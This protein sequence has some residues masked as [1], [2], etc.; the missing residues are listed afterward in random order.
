MA[1]RAQ[2]D[3]A[4]LV[5]LGGC[6]DPLPSR[7]WPGRSFP[8]PGTRP[9][10]PATLRARR[11]PPPPVVLRWPG[12]RRNGA[13]STGTNP[14]STG[15]QHRTAPAHLAPCEPAVCAGLPDG[16]PSEIGAVVGEQHRTDRSP[17]EPGSGP[18]S[19]QSTLSG[20]GLAD[21]PEPSL[22]RR[23][24]ESHAGAVPDRK[25]SRSGACGRAPL[26]RVDGDSGKR[27]R[28]LRARCRPRALSPAPSSRL[29]EI[30]EAK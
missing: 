8:A 21:G 17:L 9:H 20:Y 5:L 16:E 26:T 10:A 27:R 3:E 19:C 7:G 23:G 14:T 1:V 22:A 11:S 6:D 13:R 18:T 30:V 24:G 25:R 28:R 29:P 15:C 2:D 12:R 4:D